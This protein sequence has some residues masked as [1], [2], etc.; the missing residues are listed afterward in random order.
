MHGLNWRI[1]QALPEKIT[2][3][4]RNEQARAYDKY[5]QKRKKTGKRERW[6]YIKYKVKR[7]IE[8]ETLHGKNMLIIGH[9]LLFL[10][11]KFRESKPKIIY[12]PGGLKRD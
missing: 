7:R 5:N 12:H 2:K 9:F 11:I 10:E 1:Y 4:K 6:V 3:T 8:F